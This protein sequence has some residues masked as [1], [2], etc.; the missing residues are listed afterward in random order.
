MNNL[1]L[2]TLIFAVIALITVPFAVS[3]DLNAQQFQEILLSSVFLVA[4]KPK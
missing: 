4:L 2:S 1:L 3:L